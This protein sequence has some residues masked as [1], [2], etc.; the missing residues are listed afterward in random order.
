MKNE[1]KGTFLCDHC[2]AYLISRGERLFVGPTAWELLSNGEI[3][4]DTDTKCT[5]CEEEDTTEDSRLCM[6]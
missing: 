2:I 6:F 1:C 5:W 3:T 4:E